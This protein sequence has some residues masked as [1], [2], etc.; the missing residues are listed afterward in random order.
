MTER[1]NSAALAVGDLVCLYRRRSKG[2]GIILRYCNDIGSLI[3]EDPRTVMEVYRDFAIKDWRRRE[4][5][6]TQIC[7]KSADPDL[8]Y[9][10]F[11]YNTAYKGKLKIKFA[12]IE[13]LKKPSNHSADIV[14]S[15]NGWFPADWLRSY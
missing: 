8:V 3:N 12:F 15:Q 6:K 1:T 5:F 4:D 10:F 7:Q 11:L 14:Y 2:L 9:D 13:W